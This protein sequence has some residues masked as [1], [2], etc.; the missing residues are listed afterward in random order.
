MKYE[1]NKIVRALHTALLPD[2][3]MERKDPARY[4]S[5]YQDRILNCLDEQEKD[6]RN[7][8]L[9]LAPGA[10]FRS[11]KHA[12]QLK[13]SF[14]RIPVID[15][16]NTRALQ[17]LYAIFYT[18][19]S[20]DFNMLSDDLQACYYR[21]FERLKTLLI[22]IRTVHNDFCDRKS[23]V[24][25]FY[26][27]HRME[28][29]E[30]LQAR[31]RKRF[32]QTDAP[33]PLI[34]QQL[35][36]LQLIQFPR[37]PIT[38]ELINDCKGILVKIGYAK[39][40]R[41]KNKGSIM[42]VFFNLHIEDEE[43]RET[44]IATVRELDKNQQTTDARLL[45]FHDQVRILNQATMELDRR[46]DQPRIDIMDSLRQWLDTE[47]TYLEK[48]RPLNPAPQEPAPQPAGQPPASAKLK[49]NSSVHELSLLFDAL[50]E[51]DFVEN[52]EFNDLI[53]RIIPYLKTARVEEV[54]FRSMQSKRYEKDPAV[55]RKLYEKVKRVLE[56]IE[57]E[58]KK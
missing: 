53:R 30:K 27:M 34:S 8:D 51:S 25:H 44:Y 56:V 16:D 37:W 40:L 7:P 21:I 20:D 18:K 4:L 48:V 10:D 42:Q 52:A 33:E 58:M 31:I 45:F 50:V 3:V 55:Y 24:P 6:L 39:V 38:Y 41:R 36:K 35:W 15:R 32:E 11:A 28:I 47:I 29:A 19:Y 23:T 1:L 5:L 17:V 43:L 2:K 14:D 49:V 54:A 13:N 26:R 46:Y 22:Y 57:R 12:P 9:F